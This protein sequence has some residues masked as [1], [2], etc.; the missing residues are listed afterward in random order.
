MHN[1]DAGSPTLQQALFW[2]NLYR[3]LLAVDETALQRMRALILEEPARERG[4]ANY[5]ADVELIEGEIE[6][7]RARLDHWE[8]LV[9]GT[10]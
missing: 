8:A 2:M 3:E 7:V 10:S 1:V 5:R 6:R 9:E 4:V